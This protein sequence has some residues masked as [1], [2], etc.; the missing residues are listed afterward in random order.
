MN[1]WIET[2][3]VA[4]AVNRGEEISANAEVVR[5]NYSLPAIGAKLGS[6]LLELIGA[7]AT[8]TNSTADGQKILH[9]F[10]SL[11]TFTP[12]RVES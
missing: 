7:A 3:M 10:L 12:I 9:A 1:P 4:N 2:A 6:V 5:S 8:S 11:E